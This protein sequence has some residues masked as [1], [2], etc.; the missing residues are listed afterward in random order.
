LVPRASYESLP[1]FDGYYLEDSWVL[2]IKTTTDEATF[3]LEAALTPAHPSYSPPKP[4][5]QHRYLRSRLVFPQ[6]AEVVW[7]A[8][9]FDPARDAN[10]DV[11]FGHIDAFHFE[12]GRYVLEGDWGRVQ[13]SSDVPSIQ[14]D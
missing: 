7:D 6:V 10:G 2:R 14:P 13:I 5:E 1:G 12:H 9:H 4:G 3:W 11:D 8:V